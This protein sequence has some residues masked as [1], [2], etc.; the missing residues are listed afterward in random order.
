[1]E[2]HLP[3]YGNVSAWGNPEL[4]AT[5]GI[6]DPHGLGWHLDRTRFDADLRLAA[7][8]AGVEIIFGRARGFIADP[9]CWYVQVGEQSL[10][11][12]WLIDASGRAACAAQR[13]GAVRTRDDALVGL[14]TWAATR[15]ENQDART[16]VETTP[17]GWWYTA[18]LPDGARILVLHLDRNE[19]DEFCKNPWRYGAALSETRHIS[20]L[21]ADT[22][23]LT[24]FR[25]VDAC[26]GTLDRIYGA[27]WLAVGDAAMSFDPLSSQG[28]FNA[29]YCGMKAGQA[30]HAALMDDAGAV[31]TD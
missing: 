12:R 15:P 4:D 10:S 31:G 14:Y 16:F 19:A 1:V 18:P 3:C 23:A 7:C 20:K 17:D 8:E 9:E 24:K 26:G 11:G 21:V 22:E 13:F 5:D 28:I 30:V 2:K 25:N 29:L 6:R 27:R